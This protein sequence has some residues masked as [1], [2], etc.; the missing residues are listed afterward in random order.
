[1]P[2]PRRRLKKTDGRTDKP[3]ARTQEEAEAA[4]S[5]AAADT[6]SA[7]AAALPAV[8]EWTHNPWRL[9]PLKSVLALL[10]CLSVSLLAG[11]WMQSGI[12]TLLGLAL[13]GGTNSV[14]FFPVRYRLDGTGVTVHYLGAP[15]QR[16]WSHYRNAY[17][18]PQLV[19]LTT[20]TRPSPL[21]P[22][23]G[24]SLLFDPRSE[25]GRRE[26]VN[27]FIKQKLQLAAGR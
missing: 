16:E 14:L 4:A 18:H 2:Q 6:A 11:W 15:S 27:S 5:V 10:I 26:M 12:W 17:F 20:M 23:R 19:H 22:F 7:S 9:H 1:M 13:V 25:Q 21:D 24:H 8:L 3:L